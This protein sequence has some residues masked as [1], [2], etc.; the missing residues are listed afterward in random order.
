MTTVAAALWG[1]MWKKVRG[2]VGVVLPVETDGKRSTQKGQP[3][4]H[5]NGGC[6]VCRNA[7][8]ARPALWLQKRRSG[9]GKQSFLDGS[10]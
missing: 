4:S 10:C 6:L 9:K 2:K 3:G 8:T 1:A 7:L 5:H